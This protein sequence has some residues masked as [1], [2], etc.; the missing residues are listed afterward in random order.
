MAGKG[1][2]TFNIRAFKWLANVHINEKMGIFSKSF[3]LV[4]L[5]ITVLHE[6]SL[7]MD[8]VLNGFVDFE[9]LCEDFP[10]VMAFFMVSYEYYNIIAQKE[11]IEELLTDLEET[12][13]TWRPQFAMHSYRKTIMGKAVDLLDKLGL[14]NIIFGEFCVFMWVVRPL[15]V[16]SG[17][18]PFGNPW[19]PFDTQRY[20]YYLWFMHTYVGVLGGGNTINVHVFYGKVMAVIAEEFDIISHSFKCIHTGLEM[21]MEDE[22]LERA[23]QCIRYHQRLLKSCANLQKCINGIMVCQFC[24]GI[25]LCFAALA[26]FSMS[27]FNG[28]FINLVNHIVLELSELYFFCWFSSKLTEHGQKISLGIYH[29]C[30]YTRGEKMKRMLRFTMMRCDKPIVIKAGNLLPIS[31]GS[32]IWILQQSYSFFMVLRTVKT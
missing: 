9:R 21:C 3:V 19:F 13:S 31:I 24:F 17:K 22:M 15:V 5:L 14:Y 28:A 27:A 26:T 32:Y 7:V 20:Y 8:L 10:M 6:V 23:K 16:R 12:I 30:W 2:F 1:L 25:S 18:L 4:S 11:N 29:S